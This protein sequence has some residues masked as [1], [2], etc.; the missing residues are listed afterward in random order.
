MEISKLIC[1]GDKVELR[2]IWQM[3]E[4]EKTGASAKVYK[5]KVFDF[6]PGSDDLEIA[7]PIEEGK[8]KLLP[9]NVRVE[10]LFMTKNG[11]YRANGEIVERYK[12]DNL[13]MLR[14]S[15]KTALER[16]Q[17]REFFRLSYSI[18]LEYYELTEEQ[19]KME[20]ADAVFVQIRSEENASELEKSCKM[21]DISGGGVRISTEKPMQQGQFILLTMRLTSTRTDKQCYMI[22]QVLESFLVEKGEGSRYENRIKF[23]IKDAKVQEEIIQF[24]FEEDRR[25]RSIKR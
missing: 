6:V 11:M 2:M 7:M 5:S 19:A 8:L 17:R 9:L 3:R 23:I 12:K 24:I 1:P 20:S 25:S 10:F 15:L 14:I 22:G 21:V 4:Q 13:Y 18:E 16:F